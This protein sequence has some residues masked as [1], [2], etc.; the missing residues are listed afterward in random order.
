MRVPL[1]EE[2]D[3]ARRRDVEAEASSP[4]VLDERFTSLCATDCGVGS[5]CPGHHLLEVSIKAPKNI[6]VRRRSP[7]R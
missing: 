6:D 3:S 7:K 2:V 1:E 4:G 5:A